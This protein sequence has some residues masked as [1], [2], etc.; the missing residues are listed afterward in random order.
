M[1]AIKIPLNSSVVKPGVF[2]QDCRH[3]MENSQ[4]PHLDACFIA[5]DLSER[6]IGRGSRPG[7]VGDL[8]SFSRRAVAT[9]FIIGLASFNFL[10][11]SAAALR[12]GS[13]CALP[14]SV[15]A[16]GCAIAIVGLVMMNTR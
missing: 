11:K 9:S 15:S 6:R 5:R 3:F 4:T 13:A 14:F 7:A 10:K 12:L 8:S 2:G 1:T 16:I